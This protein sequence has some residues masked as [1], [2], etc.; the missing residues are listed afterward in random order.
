[1]WLVRHCDNG[2]TERLTHPIFLIREHT[3]PLFIE[4]YHNHYGKEQKEQRAADLLKHI[5]SECEY[6]AESPEV[7][8]LRLEVGDAAQKVHLHQCRL[9]L[10]AVVGVQDRVQEEFNE[11]AQEGADQELL[12][13]GSD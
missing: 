5:Q 11:T 3:L 2:Q 8:P 7:G 12:G 6:G 13:E 9:K 4:T 1:M 10:V